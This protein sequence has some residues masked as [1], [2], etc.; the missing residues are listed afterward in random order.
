MNER[1]REI[2]YRVWTS[3]IVVLL[4]IIASGVGILYWLNS[5]MVQLSSDIS[6]GMASVKTVVSDV[7][8]TDSGV[9]VYGYTKSVTI[10]GSNA[11]IQTVIGK[12]TPNSLDYPETVDYQ[13]AEGVKAGDLCKIQLLGGIFS[14]YKIENGVLTGVVSARNVG[15]FFG[16]ANLKALT[17]ASVTMTFDEDN[18]LT[19][20]T[21][22]FNLESGKLFTLTANYTY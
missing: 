14:D 16:S 4:F 10:N 1:I 11:E 6:A 18:K 7:T 20:M 19:E 22:E 12:L 21:A 5:G 9:K 13:F 15:K 8:V 2:K 3:V 17:D